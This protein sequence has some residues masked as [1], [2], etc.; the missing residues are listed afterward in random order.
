ME[1]VAEL[2]AEPEVAVSDG[3]PEAAVAADL[4]SDTV[5][6]FT[7]RALFT[8]DRS[9]FF[10]APCPPSTDGDSGTQIFALLGAGVAVLVFAVNFANGIVAPNML[11]LEG[12]NPLVLTQ[13]DA[14]LE[15]GLR[16]SDAMKAAMVGREAP[17]VSFDYSSAG[18]GFAEYASEV[19]RYSVEY[20]VK[21]PWFG[22]VK[23]IRDVIVEVRARPS[24]HT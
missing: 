24:W 4:T 20:T 2:H 21:A 6:L 23:L 16:M 19:G 7:V 18:F 10:S 14:Y 22:A 5:S 1:P 3:I 13:G 15:P 12:A 11:A 17:A 8:T 9:A